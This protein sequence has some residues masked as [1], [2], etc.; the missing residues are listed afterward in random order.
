[1]IVAKVQGHGPYRTRCIRDWIHVYLATK[2]LPLH[3]YGQYHSSILND[4]DFEDSIKLHLQFVAAKDGNFTALTLVDFVASPEIQ[5]KL[6][7]AGVTKHSISVWTARCWL[8]RLDWRY[9]RRKNGMYVDGHEREDVVAYRMEFIK[10]WFD[11]YEPRMVVYDNDGKVLKTPDG[12]VLQGNFK[13]QRFRLILITHDESTFYANDRRKLG[14][15]PKLGKG[16]PEPKG[17]G[18]SIMVSDFLTFEWGRLTDGDDEARLLFRAGKNRDSDGYFASKDLL[19]QVSCA[20]DIFEAKTNGFA[21][22]LFLFDNAPSHRK[23]AADALSARKMV[24]GPKLIGGVRMQNGTLTSGESQSFYFPDDHPTMLGW[25]KGMEQII[26]ERGL[27]RDGLLAQCP[28]FKCQA[29]ASDCC[30]CWILFCQPDFVNQKSVLEE[31]VDSRSHICDFYPKYHCELNFIEMYW[32]AAKFQYRTTA[33]TTK[34]NEMEKNVIA[35]L[36]DV[37]LVSIICYANRAARFMSAYAQGLTG[38]DLIWIKKP[39]R[40]HRILPPSMIAEIKASIL[41]AKYS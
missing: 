5:E 13:G 28:G 23:R 27:W 34:I 33:R 25:F 21:T 14:W 15:V 32:G 29:G 11:H 7:E 39:Y 6:D 16:K 10:R 36:D 37:P 38:G 18:E 40:S 26:R 30:C 22:G 8:K 20:I 12:Y 31:L 35:C 41:A 24:K 19:E 17:E 2:K 3:R 9:G 4:E 1:M